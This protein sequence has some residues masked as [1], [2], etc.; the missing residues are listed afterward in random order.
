MT[1]IGGNLQNRIPGVLRKDDTLVAFVDA[2]PEHSILMSLLSAV[3]VACIEL[4]SEAGRYAF[5]PLLHDALSD[6]KTIWDANRRQLLVIGDVF[7]VGVTHLCLGGIDQG[8]E[9][10]FY[11]TGET[12]GFQTEIAIQRL[13]RA[14]AYPIP[15]THVMEELSMPQYRS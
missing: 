6:E 11:P 10:F 12:S 8:M 1:V 5:G 4:H 3:Q 14:G 2:R 9:T 7:D 13:V 15:L